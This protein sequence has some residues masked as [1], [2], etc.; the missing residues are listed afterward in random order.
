MGGGSKNGPNELVG[1]P[2]SD[3]HSWIF[4]NMELSPRITVK[5]TLTP[6]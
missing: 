1:D 5:P 4:T 6:T 3:L 2:A